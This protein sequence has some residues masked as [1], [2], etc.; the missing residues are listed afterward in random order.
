MR[1]QGAAKA[2]AA[3]CGRD[4]KLAD[5]EPAPLREPAKPAYQRARAIARRDHERPRVG[6]G[7][8][9][10]DMRAK[11]VGD[12]DRF[13][14]AIIGEDSDRRLRLFGCHDR[15]PTRLALRGQA[16]SDAISRFG[17]RRFKL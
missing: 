1:H 16:R 13:R 5:I 2:G 8:S 17:Q 9:V 14:A 15:Q 7:E 12:P 3:R 10:R 4:I 11:L 6:R